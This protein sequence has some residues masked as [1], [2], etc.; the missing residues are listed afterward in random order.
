MCL[1][2]FFLRLFFLRKRKGKR[3]ERRKEEGKEDRKEG[4]KER[5][6][7][8]RG[9][10]FLG[11]LQRLFTT[12]TE[13]ERRREARARKARGEEGLFIRPTLDLS[14]ALLWLFPSPSRACN[15]RFSP[16]SLLALALGWGSSV[17]WA[18]AKLL[19]LRRGRFSPKLKPEREKRRDPIEERAAEAAAAAA[20]EAKGLQ[21]T[22]AAAREPQ[23]VSPTRRSPPRLPFS[24]RRRS[25]PKRLS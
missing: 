8:E 19:G 23:S 3:K 2:A 20:A 21:R 15:S 16:C 12:S 18:K 17:C 1:C 25:F 7:G 11:D 9:A 14:L 4:R 6:E 24:R 10:V 13:E 22:A 5:R